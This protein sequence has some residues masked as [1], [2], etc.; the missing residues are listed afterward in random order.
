MGSPKGPTEIA[1]SRRFAE[2]LRGQRRLLELS[3]IGT[4]ERAGLHPREIDQ[5]ERGL[6]LPRLDTI[7]KVAG[8]LEVQP[9][10]L[11]AEMS[12]KLEEPKEK[13]LEERGDL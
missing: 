6:R 8:A 4:A 13:A 9:C 1:L 10:E 2:K 3:Q 12:W 7:V 11:L 5:L